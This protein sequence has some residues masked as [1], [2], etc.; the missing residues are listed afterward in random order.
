MTIRDAHSAEQYVT[1]WAGSSPTR[2]AGM[3]L[4]AAEGL[5]AAAGLARIAGLS[6]EAR[7]LA[8]AAAV[9]HRARIEVLS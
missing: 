6:G 1:A 9:L 4:I 8:C 3:Y 2:R 5:D 7:R